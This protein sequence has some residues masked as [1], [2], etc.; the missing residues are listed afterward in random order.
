VWARIA[1]DEDD[2]ESAEKIIMIFLLL[3][4]GLLIGGVLGLTGAGGSVIAVPLL[5]VL[6]NLE[7]T[8][9]TGLALGVVAASS[10]YGAVQKIWHRE[11]LWIP[12]ILFGFSGAMLAPMGRIL[13]K[14]VSPQLLISSF[15]VLSIVIAARMLWQSIRQPEQSNVVRASTSA[16]GEAYE[17]LLCRLSENSKFDWRFRCMAGLTLGG[18]LTGIFS[19]FFGVGGGFLIVPFLN[20]LN[21]VSMRNAVATSLVIIAT[22][23]SS[24]F[25]AHLAT[26]T[27]NWHQLAWLCIGGIIGM[28]LGSVLARWIAG[29]Y[30]QRIFAV[31]IMVMTSLLIIR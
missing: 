4:I 2:V 20:Q 10:L 28:V 11:V 15:A 3:T 21:S 6:L 27:V 16:G 25:L 22:V 23:S 26:Q 30:L 17:A 18:V 19:G 14:L 1:Y 29:V 8:T 7:P 9:A 12:A 13:A 5:L 31:T 24:G